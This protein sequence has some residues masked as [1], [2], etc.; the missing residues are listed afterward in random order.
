MKEEILSVKD[1]RDSVFENRL[2]KRILVGIR[3]YFK[4]NHEYY[5]LQETFEVNAML[6]GAAELY[7]VD[8]KI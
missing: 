1:L 4:R 3:E 6:I 7:H 2:N 5:S 8:K